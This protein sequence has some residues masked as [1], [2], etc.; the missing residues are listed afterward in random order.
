M[1]LTLFLSGLIDR[2]ASVPVPFVAYGGLAL[3]FGALGAA[4][5]LANRDDV[6]ATWLGGVFLLIGAESAG[7]LLRYSVVPAA[8]WL[9]QIRPDAFL[10][11]FLWRFLIEFPSPPPPRQR[12]WAAMTATA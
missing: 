2:S 11:A 7:P 3:T 4:L 5:L 6:R 1:A 9:N 12:R 10:P 8:Q